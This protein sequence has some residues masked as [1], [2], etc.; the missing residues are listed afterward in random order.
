MAA[1]IFIAS[2]VLALVLAYRP[3]GDYMYRVFTPTKH[4]RVERGI[5]RLIGVDPQSEQSWPVYARSVLAFSA[6]SILFLYLFE[7]VQSHL[8]LS[9]GFRE[10]RSRSGVEHG[11]QFHHE[12][13]LAGIFR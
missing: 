12:H 5:Y 1:A 6:V 9:L 11:R 10:R 4:S 3:A 13:E 7:R 2:L 8:M